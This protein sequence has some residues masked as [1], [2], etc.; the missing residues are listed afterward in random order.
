MGRSLDY[1]FWLTVSCASEIGIPVWAFLDGRSMGGAV[2]TRIAERPNVRRLFN[3]VLA[4]GAALMVK[5]PGCEL[6][7]CPTIPI[8]YLTNTSE[9]GPIEH[10]IARVK[11]K[12]EEERKSGVGGGDEIVTPALHAVH[13]EGHNWTNARERWRAFSCLVEWA[14][15]GSL[16]TE[17]RFDGTRPALLKRSSLPEPVTLPDGSL[18]LR[19]TVVLVEDKTTFH[20]G[21]TLADLDSIRLRIN[22]QCRIEHRGVS[23]AV[24]VGAYPFCGIPDTATVLSETPEDLLCLFSLSEFRNKPAESVLALGLAL[25]DEVLIVA[26]KEPPRTVRRKAMPPPIDL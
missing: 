10:Y 18:A 19:T 6:N 21:V 26:P 11:D 15:V 25:G 24:H 7:Y 3:G 9:H 13:R 22:S 5:E 17:F 23:T 1:C 16:V 4:M 14:F 8:L 2:S 20:L 12:A